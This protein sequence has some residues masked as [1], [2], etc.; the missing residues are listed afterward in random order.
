MHH[1]LRKSQILVVSAHL[2]FNLLGFGLWLK[3]ILD[4]LKNLTWNEWLFLERK[5]AVTHHLQIEQVFHKSLHE[6]TLAHHHVAVAKCLRYEIHLQGSQA[7]DRNDLLEEEDDGEE[8][9][10]QFMAHRA[11]E[12][13]AHDVALLLFAPQI[14][15]E[16]LFDLLSAIVDV[17]CNR[18]LAQ[19]D[20]LF[21]TDC[22][23]LVL[24]ARNLQVASH[25]L[26][27]RGFLHGTVVVRVV[28]ARVEIVH[29]VNLLLSFVLVT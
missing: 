28:I 6:P 20:L 16:F 7:E 19:V 26:L 24:N 3:D 1:I 23:E 17:N 11:C 8:W 25:E 27:P 4:Q 10:A 5:H 29:L 9:S 15:Q 22:K 18:W 13:L 21:D 2:D 12:T 14:L